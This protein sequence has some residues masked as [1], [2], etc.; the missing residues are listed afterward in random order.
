MSLE[1]NSALTGY[2]SIDRPWMKH[3]P[4]P[5][6]KMIH[7]PDCTLNDYLRSKAPSGDTLALHYYGRD[8]VWSTIFDESVRIARSLRALGFGEND[9]I[10]MFLR[11]VP[12]FVSLVLATELIG[13]SLVC[14]DNELDENVYAAVHSGSKVIFA[15]DFMSQEE[16]DAY[17][18][19]GIEKIVL[20]DPLRSGD[21]RSMPDYVTKNLDALYA[22]GKSSS[23]AIMDWDAFLTLGDDYKG[24]VEAAVDIHRPLYRSFTSGS[25]GPSKQVIHS[26]HTIISILAQINFF[27]AFAPKP[28]KWLVCCFPPALVGVLIGM[29]LMPLS[30]GLDLI[31]DPFVAPEDIDLEFMRYKPN[32]M[33]MVPMILESLIYSDRIPEDYD[34]S[35][36]RSAGVGSDSYN[37]AQSRK[38]MAFLKAHN[39]QARHTV[40]Y[41]QSEA[42][43]AMTM[44]MSQTPIGN[45]LVGVPLPLTVVSVFE[46]GTDKELTYNQIGEI[47]K[48]GAGNMLGYD[49]PKATAEAL[50]LHGDGNVWLHTGDVGYMNE[51]GEL[52]VLGRGFTPRYGGGNLESLTIDNKV[53]DANIEGIKD[54]FSVI[55]PDENHPGFYEPFLFVVLEEGYKLEDVE[56]KIYASLEPHRQ[57]VEIMVL[58]TR[59]YFHFKTYRRG[60]A[61]KINNYRKKNRPKQMA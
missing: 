33:P 24:Q 30:A 47:C 35:H 3:W 1:T 32:H 14:R 60:M 28:T 36:F 5:L 59:P 22:S 27:G 54:H 20:L 18:K 17:I 58:D 57:P 48:T 38:A 23:P 39:C 16:T 8:F 11:N 25:T 13:A 44:P 45:G 52:F 51:D 12:E 15:H 19:A 61:Q 56:E 7:I 29:V 53:A 2:P 37:N 21:R 50:K 4:E 43:T 34:M 42:G 31:L 49:D 9:Q 40:D 46:P 10:P 55:A 26:S 41:G 6:L